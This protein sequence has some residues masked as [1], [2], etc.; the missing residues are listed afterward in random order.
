VIEPVVFKCFDSERWV[1]EQGIERERSRALGHA[2]NLTGI[3][4]CDDADGR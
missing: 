2:R 4:E 3:Q 1:T